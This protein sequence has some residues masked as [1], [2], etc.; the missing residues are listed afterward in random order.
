MLEVFREVQRVLKDD[1]T[2]WLNLSDSYVGSGKCGQSEKKRGKNW[3]PE[4]GH[5]GKA[6]WP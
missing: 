3:Q 2:L 6:L 1:G 4:Y 5:K